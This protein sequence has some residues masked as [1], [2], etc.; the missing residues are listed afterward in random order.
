MLSKGV[1]ESFNFASKVKVVL[2]LGL[3]VVPQREVHH[4]H[5]FVLRRSNY[6]DWVT[7]V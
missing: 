6:K 4:L 7:L 1:G 2:E 5:L 3:V